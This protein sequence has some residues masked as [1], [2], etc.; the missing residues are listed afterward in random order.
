V[1]PYVGEVGCKRLRYR[2]PLLLTM[3]HHIYSLVLKKTCGRFYELTWHVH[4][5]LATKKGSMRLIIFD[6]EG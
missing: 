3:F 5:I 2:T 6:F 1:K 4:S